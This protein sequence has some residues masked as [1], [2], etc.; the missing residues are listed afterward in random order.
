MLI[1]WPM[2]IAKTCFLILA[3]MI[4]EWA[5][6]Y[7]SW[8]GVALV[9]FG[10]VLLGDLLELVLIVRRR[11]RVSQFIHDQESEIRAVA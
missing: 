7:Q 4:G 8:F 6:A 1:R 9:V 11:D 2:M 10:G 3:L 5:G